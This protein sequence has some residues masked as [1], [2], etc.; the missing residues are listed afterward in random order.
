VAVSIPI[1]LAFVAML[2]AIHTSPLASRRAWSLLGLLF[3]SMWG[4]D[5]CPQLLPELT[6][7]RWGGSS[8]VSFADLRAA[9]WALNVRGWGCS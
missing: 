3:G 2:V 8:V 1:P 4:G 7:A 9:P 6:V 5:R